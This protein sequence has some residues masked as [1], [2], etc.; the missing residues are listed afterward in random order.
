A[1]EPGNGIVE[2]AFVPSA[3]RVRQKVEHAVA[4]R[5]Y[6][7]AKLVEMFDDDVDGRTNAFGLGCTE[8]C[9]QVIRRFRHVVEAL[10]AGRMVEPIPRVERLRELLERGQL[11]PSLREAH[12][13]LCAL[14]DPRG[15]PECALVEQHDE[16]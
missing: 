6:G 9:A 3:L 7:L 12:M 10:L 1:V 16:V 15:S 2:A 8:H 4:A 14:S 13:L 11:A 5:R